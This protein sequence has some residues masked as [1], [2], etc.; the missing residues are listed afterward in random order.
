MA[1]RSLYA[2]AE[3]RSGPLHYNVVLS[4]SQTCAVCTQGEATINIDITSRK[5]HCA[6]RP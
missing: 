3:G 5:Q 1:H 2:A 6:T 4:G